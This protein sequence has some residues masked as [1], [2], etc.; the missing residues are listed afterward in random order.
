MADR[1]RAPGEARPYAAPWPGRGWHPHPRMPAPP[2]EAALPGRSFN[3]G[4]CDEILILHSDVEVF[5]DA[6]LVWFGLVWGVKIVWRWFIGGS[7]SFFFV[8]C[9]V[10]W[11]VECVFFQV[12]W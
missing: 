5:L 4:V 10:G 11:F 3:V 2:L 7:F 9:V 1:Y 12:E 6:I 8:G